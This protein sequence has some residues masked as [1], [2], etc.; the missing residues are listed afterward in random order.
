MHVWRL[1]V[2]NNHSASY[3]KRYRVGFKQQALKRADEPV[4]TDNLVYEELAS[5][6]S[7]FGAGL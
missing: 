7:G 1:F 5:V 2:R 3:L 6:H 4:V